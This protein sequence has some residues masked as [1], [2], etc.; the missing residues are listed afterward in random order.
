MRGL[1]GM[2]E[3]CPTREEDWTSICIL[4]LLVLV[5]VPLVSLEEG[6]GLELP[7]DLQVEFE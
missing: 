2:E 6:T 7:E 1:E 5:V 3:G 4:P